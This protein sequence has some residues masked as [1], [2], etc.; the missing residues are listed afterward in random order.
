MNALSI[1][2]HIKPILNHCEFEPLRPMRQEGRAKPNQI[3]ELF[4]A[5]LG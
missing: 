5:R 3:V 4:Q 2:I 1:A